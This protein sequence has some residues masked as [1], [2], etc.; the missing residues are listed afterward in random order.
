VTEPE[1]GRADPRSDGPEP[2]RA[3]H[4]DLVETW[5]VI[6]ISLAAILTAWSAYESQRWGGVQAADYTLAN[7]SR[8][9]SVR[10]SGQA[11][12]KSA[13]DV[14]VFTDWVAA[15]AAGDQR[16]A[17]FL[18]ARF[19]DEF[20]PAFEAWQRLPRVDNIPPGTP[21]SLPEYRLADQVKSDKLADRAGAY[22]QAGQNANQ[23]A[24][25]F[26]LVSVLCASVLFFGGI[27]T[28]LKR[29]SLKMTLLGVGSLLFLWATIIALTLPQNV[30]F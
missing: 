28:R 19:R 4:W 3:W 23:I 21:F 1:H 22:F 29:P 6:L 13:V 12:V 24:D 8:M 9:E 5:S 17:A 18:E 11:T 14:N 30:G 16:L 27:S 7:A 15:K 10:A 20:V 25:N 2:N 26:V